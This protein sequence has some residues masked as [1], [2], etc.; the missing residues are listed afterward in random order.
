MSETSPR[1]N[2]KPSAG[3][4]LLG[5]LLF[6]LAFSFPAKPLLE[7]DSSW[8]Q[9]LAYF[10]HRGFPFGESIVF[11]YGPLGFLMGNTYMGLYY[12]AYLVWQTLFS[13]LA[14]ALIVGLARPLAGVSRFVYF[15]F[16][17]LWGVGYGDAL[18]MIVIAY[19]GWMLL[20]LAE[21]DRGKLRPGLVGSLLAV[22]ALIKFTN[23]LF[24]GFVVVM[25][26]LHDWLKG[27]RP[28]AGTL[29]GCFAGVF[30]FGWMLLGQSLLALIPYALNSLEISSGYQAAMGLPTPEGQLTKALLVMAGIGGYVLWHLCSQPDRLRALARLLILAAFLFL[31]WKH[32]FVRADGHMLG[33]FYC[34]L[35]PVVAFPVLFREELRHRWIPRLCLVWAGVFCI[36][37]MR[38]TFTSSIDYAFSI[39]N[40]RLT[41]NLGKMADLKRTRGDLEGAVSHWEREAKLEKTQSR[42]GDASLDVLGFEQAIALFNG[43]N[44]TP[45]P[46]FQSYSAYTPKLS[47]LN[48]AYLA[49]EDAPDFLL[50]KLQ[51]IDDRPLLADDSQLMAL[52]P[53]LYTY[54]LTEKDF[55]LFSRR[56]DT[57][58]VATLSPRLVRSLDVALGDPVDLTEFGT[59][60]V[61]VEIDLPFSWAG[62]ARKFLYKPPLVFLRVTDLDGKEIRYRVPRS[63]ATAG[64]QIN[65]LV[66]D[67]DSYLE[68]HGGESPRQVRELRIEVE[69]ADLRWVEDTAFVKLSVLPSTDLEQEYHK[70][71]QR[72]QF[73]GFSALPRDFAAKTPVSRQ[74]IDGT[75]VVILH[76][77][78]FMN[79]VFEGAER[80]TGSY[81]YPAGAYTNGGET[82][83]ATFR[84]LWTDGDDS[85]ELWNRRLEPLT[86]PAD[87]GLHNLSLDLSTLPPRG[88]LR[89]EI[90][91]NDNPGWDWTAWANIVVE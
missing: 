70:Q 44:Y 62:R 35:V 38:G 54:E 16:F 14:A 88:E 18:H 31:N 85:R 6:V 39:T 77:P 11:T 58:D 55:H 64:F 52:F 29:L 9:A 33:F 36:L 17:A 87:R 57:P 3:E 4:I 25:V 32:G 41:Q 79:F 82:D 5:L 49:G 10:L 61:W 81:G 42:V 37:G 75:E 63:L 47:A 27:R 69:D 76:A 13:A 90:S 28:Q 40:E 48:A 84:V 8:R 56:S 30:L 59:D 50:L 86:N 45:R 71:L 12:E 66:T 53:H 80:L 83:G 65:P 20:N 78:S 24:A 22:L 34:A 51:T 7:L 43:F 1:P 60:H 74:K 46:T 2:G 23:L 73:E 15:I 72:L 91:V 21:D 89:F 67:F 68:A 19:L 26:C